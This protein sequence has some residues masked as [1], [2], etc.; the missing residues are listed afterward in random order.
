MLKITPLLVKLVVGNEPKNRK[1]IKVIL[2]TKLDLQITLRGVF[3]IPDFG[4]F[5]FIKAWHFSFMPSAFW[6]SKMHQYWYFSIQQISALS[7]VKNF[8]IN[9]LISHF[10]AKWSKSVLQD[11][12]NWKIKM[13]W[14][15]G[16]FDSAMFIFWISL[17][18]NRTCSI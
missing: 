18:K 9:S 10:F 13:L 8:W 6:F 5:E 1:F 11:F 4:H 2:D 7:M 12:A 3:K 17:A 16:N 15:N 14:K